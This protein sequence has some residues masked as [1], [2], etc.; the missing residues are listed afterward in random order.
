MQESNN[1]NNLKNN[2]MNKITLMII[3][4]IIST[5][6]QIVA[7]SEFTTHD[8]GLIYSENTMNKLGKIVK[9][10]NLKYKNMRFRQSF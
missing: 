5:S 6:F 3:M 7:Q 4:M 9:D 8:N 2:L 1:Y 10:L